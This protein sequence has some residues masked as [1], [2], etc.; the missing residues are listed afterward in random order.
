MSSR[1]EILAAIRKNTVCDFPKPDYS[2]LETEAMTFADPVAQF[3][4]ALK[5]VGGQ[6]IF[7]KEGEDINALIKSQYPEAK[8]IASHLQE[9]SCANVNPDQLET[10]AE[11]EDVD[12]AVLKAD[13]GIAENGAVWYEQRDERHR[14]I[15]FIPECLV[16]ILD[17]KHIVN[18]MHEAYR[19]IGEEHKDFAGFI[20]GPSKTADI[21]QA[22]VFGAHGAAKL[23]VIIKE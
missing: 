11:L 19:N 17:K 10:P 21:E 13:W 20:S 15:Y 5:A 12:V 9:I 7:L 1:D 2:I 14:A 16:F 4:E 3:C 6:G 23:T 22:L 18:N 8:K